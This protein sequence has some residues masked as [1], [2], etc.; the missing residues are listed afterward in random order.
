MSSEFDLIRRHFTRATPGAVLGVGDDAAL[1]ALTPGCQWAVSTDMLVSGR[2]FFPDTDPE[3]LGHKAMAVNLS[4]LAA[5]GARPRWAT[6]ALAL[7]EADE[8][9][10]SAFARGLYALADAHRVELVGGDTTRG[11]CNI[12]ITVMGE[13]G[14]DQAL[15]RDAARLGDDIWVS[16]ELGGA[17]LALRHLRGELDLGEHA[18]ACLERLQRPQPRVELGLRLVGLAH[19]AIDLSDGLLADLGHILERSGVG[20]VIDRASIPVADAFAL[21]SN[22][23]PNEFPHEFD[24]CALAGGDDYELCFTAAPERADALRQVALECGVAVTRIGQITATP[25]LRDA[26][27]RVFDHTKGY[28]H[29][30]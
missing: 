12:S 19:A 27:G 18:A 4:D 30:A 6:L 9:W 22:K 14:V 28:D 10:L 20:A 23:F 29:F 13:V 21:F 2:H 25:G 7:P 3:G 24:A 26:L 8:A 17:A 15:R 11:P 1:L 5:M 16:G